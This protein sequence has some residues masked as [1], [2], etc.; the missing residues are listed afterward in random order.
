VEKFLNAQNESG[1]TALHWAAI[2]GHTAILKI[3]LEA[4]ADPSILNKAGHDV[5]YEAELNDKLEAVELLLTDSDALLAPIAEQTG[6][7]DHAS[8]SN[9]ASTDLNGHAESEV[10]IDNSV[11]MVEEGLE[12]VQISNETSH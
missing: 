8:S 2:N 10:D 6:S 11:T 7:G 4:G 5:V 3:L 1:N 12:N 9:A